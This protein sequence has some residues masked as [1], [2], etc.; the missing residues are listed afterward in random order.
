MRDIPEPLSKKLPIKIHIDPNG[1]LRITFWGDLLKE[2][3]ESF[4]SELEMGKI[5][6]SKLSEKQGKKIKILLDMTQ[7]TGEYSA[8]AVQLL[9][10]FAKHNS[11]YVEKTAS[12]G[13]SEKVKTAGEI[14]MSLSQRE[15]IKICKTEDEARAWL[16]IEEPKN[17]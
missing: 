11:K 5:V 12:F 14:I 6:I 17:V 10:D 2:N 4:A 1:F 9:T 3:I 15:N 16:E 7:F 13:G 8:E